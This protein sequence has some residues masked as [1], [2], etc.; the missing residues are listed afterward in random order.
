MPLRG[1]IG[2]DVLANRSDWR[3]IDNPFG[4]AE[5]PVVLLPAINPDIAL[6]HA[7]WG[8][9]LGNVWTGARRD[10]AALAHA[11]RATLVTV[12]EIVEGDLTEDARMAAGTLSA[13]Y[14]TAIAEAKNGAAPVGLASRYPADTGH[15]R[16]Y[17]EHARTAEGFAR[18]LEKFVFSEGAAA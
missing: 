5:D 18:Y 11:S 14:V 12:E 7:A 17:A 4:D 8:D 2:T 15:M 16:D 3:V 13:V 6:F 1:I 9:R 10:L